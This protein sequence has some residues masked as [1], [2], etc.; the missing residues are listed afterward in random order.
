MW[1]HVCGKRERRGGGMAT[2]LTTPAHLT[3]T[4]QLDQAEWAATLIE[5]AHDTEQIGPTR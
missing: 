5:K 4:Q 3:G 1:R 2:C